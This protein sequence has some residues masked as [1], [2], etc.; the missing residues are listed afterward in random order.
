M[1][2]KKIM[3]NVDEEVLEEFDKKIGL[4]KRSAYINEMLKKEIKKK[5]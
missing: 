5:E 4:V 1:A 3:I 2:K